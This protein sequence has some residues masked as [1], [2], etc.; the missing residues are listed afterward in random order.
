MKSGHIWPDFTRISLGA[1]DVTPGWFAVAVNGELA[2]IAAAQHG[3]FTRAQALGAGASERTVRRRMATGLWVVT[4]PGVY[5]PLWSPAG[6]LHDVT[7]ASLWAGGEG[8]VSHRAAAVLLGLDGFEQAPV[9][10]T[11][12]RRRSAPRPWV[13]LHAG[14]LAACD[15]ETV[16]PLTVTNATRTLL[17][18]GAVAHEE[19]VEI[20]LED[21]LRRGLTSLPRL[22]WRLG[23]ATARGRRGPAV[24]RRILADR[25]RAAGPAES[26]LEVRVIRILRRAGLPDPVRQHPVILESGKTA[27]IDL[28]YPDRRVAIECESWRYHGG[29]QAF[30]QDLTRRNGLTGLGWQVVHV[31]W[32]QAT[33]DPDGVIAAV[34]RLL[35]ESYPAAA[36]RGA[37]DPRRLA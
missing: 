29:R 2:S 20:A 7:A 12:P 31:T 33:T 35:G 8:A 13:L 30:E 5:R 4:L 37:P 10:L 24:V 27:R 18:L 26:P 34:R 15:L 16:G 19:A 11:L 32:K 6:W 3:A 1:S 36:S 28:A 25:G 14:P 9:E 23:E 21:A 22:R 17:D